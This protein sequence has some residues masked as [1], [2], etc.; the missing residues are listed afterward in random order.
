[1]PL[2]TC[3]GC[4][5]TV[6]GARQR[7][8][9]APCRKAQWRQTTR[10]TLAPGEEVPTDE[11]KRHVR[12]HGYVLLI[13]RIGTRQYVQTY[14]HRVINGRV[15]TAEHVHHV[16]HDRADN[17]PENLRPLSAVEHAAEHGNPRWWVQAARMY[18]SG[19]STYQIGKQLTRNPATVYRA[20]IQLGVPLR[21]EARIAI[22]HRERNRG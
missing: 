12:R 9:C 8:R 16:N 14:E 18:S 13:W 5:T 1:M 4:G 10:R 20:L 2:I 3:I 15:T 21:K 17:R 7:R 6:E 11:P 22:P 19:L